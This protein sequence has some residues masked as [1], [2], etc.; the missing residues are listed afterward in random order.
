MPS[1]NAAMFVEGLEEDKK[2]S[3]CISCGKCARICPQ[4]IDIP[5][6]MKDLTERISKMPRWADE[7]KKREALAKQNR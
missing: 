1:I 6:A 5:A 3:A 2:P 7:C 4:N